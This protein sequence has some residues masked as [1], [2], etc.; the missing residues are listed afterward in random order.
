[1]RNT[2][3]HPRGSNIIFIEKDL[4]K[5]QS[6]NDI[7]IY[8]KQKWF[9]SKNQ[10][11]IEVL[12]VNG[13]NLSKGILEKENKHVSMDQDQQNQLLDEIQKLEP[14]NESNPIQPLV[15]ARA[16]LYDKVKSYLLPFGYPQSVTN[17]Y[18]GFYSWLFLQNVAGSCTYLM[19]MEA[20]LHS[21]GVSS[22]AFGW[23]AAITWVLKDGLGSIGMIVYAKIKG[24]SN[25]F[26]SNILQSKFVADVFHNTGV[27]FELLT[28]TFPHLFLVLASCANIF[29]G[30]SGVTNGACKASIN[31]EMSKTN[32]MGDITAKGHTQG[33]FAY[34]T[35]L[36]LGIGI[37]VTLQNLSP[38]LPSAFDFAGIWIV[39]TSLAATH[40]YCGYRALRSLNFT[41]LNTNRALINV[42]QY[43][44]TQEVKTP[45][46]VREERLEP[47]L[48]SYDQHP[49]KIKI[50]SSIREAFGSLLNGTVME[51]LIDIF[52]GEKF[53]VYHRKNEIHILLRSD[54][55]Q[56]DILKAILTTTY[57]RQKIQNVDTWSDYLK[58][59]LE[60]SQKSLSPFMEKLHESG[61]QTDQLALNVLNHRID[62]ICMKN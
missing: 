33:L 56:I 16:F 36:A 41:T 25:S 5:T 28:L 55:K 37:N 24:D 15:Q 30:L 43:L 3:N 47:I 10:K 61:W 39:F 46:E 6:E 14:R 34:I 45:E 29:K 58:E 62:W 22:S 21:V 57:L 7:S 38:L 18:P 49:I 54:A 11:P 48:L 20:L 13:M 2:S 4:R 8:T 12:E 35:G 42:L 23:A 60:F 1:M 19:S 59:S 31:K 40:L 32:N 27:A 17:D 51:E 50:G 44:N 9:I 26:D 53:F 52:A